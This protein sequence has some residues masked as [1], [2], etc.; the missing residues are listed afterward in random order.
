MRN[1]FINLAIFI[2]S[3]SICAFALE[4]GIRSLFPHYDPSG[5]V[6][7]ITDQSGLVVAKNKGKFRQIKNTGDYDVEININDL[8]LRES[9]SFKSSSPTD[10]YLVGDSF[11][12]GWGVEEADRFSNKLE[13]L[14]PKNRIFNISIPTDIN[15]YEK[16]L[17]YAKKN[18]AKIKRLIV[19]ITIENDLKI[20]HKA[21]LQKNGSNKKTH[22]SEIIR[23]FKY[24]L[25]DHSAVY[26]LFTSQIHSAPLLKNLMVSFG[27][28]TPNTERILNVRI[29]PKMIESSAKRLKTLISNYDAYVL[30]IPS[31][32]LWIGTKH[33]RKI[34]NE[35][36]NNFISALNKN[37]L[38]YI[39]MRVPMEQSKGPLEFHFKYDG[40]W[41]KRGHRLAA[42][43]L[44]KAISPN[45]D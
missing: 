20:Y 32:S 30:I 39:D 14:L 7:F 22:S 24:Y 3:I 34:A 18:G 25:R 15:G 36:H 43:E 26:F 38:K 35:I 2:V 8:G 33:Q 40:H 45:W 23:S 9:K 19:G 13:S 27:L 10:I 4:Y 16:L 1:I 37:N 17:A 42:E 11:S 31:R 12:F 21:Q 28:I 29:T 44:K 41:N 6:G 5:H